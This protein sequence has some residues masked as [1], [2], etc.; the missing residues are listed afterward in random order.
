MPKRKNKSAKTK[1]AKVLAEL[2]R[3]K[4]RRKNR[5]NKIKPK[6]KGA[7]LRTIGRTV[8]GLFGAPGRVIGGAAGSLLGHITGTGAYHASMLGG[9][10]PG[11]PPAFAD[12]S[13]G[14]VTIS[15]RE[16]LLDVLSSPG[17]LIRVTQLL[18]P[19][20]ATLFPW[21]SGISKNFEEWE[22]LGIV[23]YYNPTCGTAVGSTDTSLG[24]VV[25]ATDYDAYDSNYTNKQEMEMSQFAVS[26][27]PPYPLMHAVE[28]KNKLNPLSR[29][30]VNHGST[31]G[32]IRLAD[33]GKF[34][35]AVQGMQATDKT[36]GELWVS[37]KI[38]FHKPVFPP[39]SLSNFMSRFACYMSV[40]PLTNATTT[41][42]AY[43]KHWDTSAS[44]I[45]FVPVVEQGVKLE[46]VTPPSVGFNNEV[47]RF[48]DPSTNERI[49][50]AQYLVIN[51]TTWIGD[52]S[53]DSPTG[54]VGSAARFTVETY[55]D[56]GDIIPP[57][58]MPPS[59][60]ATNT[61]QGYQVSG[62]GSGAN[63]TSVTIGYAAEPTSGDLFSSL[64]VYP[65]QTHVDIPG[66]VGQ[67]TM[68]VSV[69]NA[70]PGFA[71]DVKK[72]LEEADLSTQIA[73]IFQRLKLLESRPVRGEFDS[74]D[75]VDS[76][77]DLTKSVLVNALSR[78]FGKSSNSSSSG[79]P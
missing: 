25:M 70:F 56:A 3:N 77:V 45:T 58:V 69:P 5:K 23:F 46:I 13:D 12:N 24:T 8:G 73:S 68:I 54:P 61:V 33:L 15:H 4:S 9:V 41:T 57:G 19:G 16:Y 30:R 35:L 50:G 64:I 20:N 79:N 36:L 14:S 28:C 34:Q 2:V 59:L 52:S 63:A 51:Y 71:A 6:K 62:V 65:A 53:V 42:G 22:P 76:P 27:T 44:T 60:P 78:A 55:N 43:L 74:A 38:K 26:G 40:Y 37:Y 17:F 49:D 72:F 66:G 31:P 67:V 11:G 10:N 7:L 1:T 21:L 75:G 47:W 18:N 32:D 29:F 48:I 39:T